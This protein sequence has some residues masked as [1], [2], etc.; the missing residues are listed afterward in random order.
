MELEPD[1]I[2]N[3]GVGMPTDVANIA[4][5]EHVSDKMVLTTEAGGIGGV[6]AGL[7]HFGQSY[8][9]EAMIA[10]PSLKLLPVSI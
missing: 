3:L 10:M 5:E 8:N 4:A 6:P 9:A 7:P 1:S 2:V